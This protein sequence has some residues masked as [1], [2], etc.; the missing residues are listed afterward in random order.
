M[1]CLSMVSLCALSGQRTLSGKITNAAGEPLIGAN[2]L[3]KGTQAGTIANADGE[4]QL[5]VPSDA[6]ALLISY[7]GYESQEVPIGLTNEINVTL[8]EGV[9]MEEVVVS[10]LGIDRNSRSVPYSNQTVK[11]DEL[12]SSPNKNALAALQG[13]VAGVRISEGSGSPGA[14]TRIIL[15][16]EG[17]LTGNNNALI[18]ID[19]IP[20]D[21]SATR[22]GDPNDR[23]NNIA[24]FGFADYGN[25]FN[26]LNPADIEAVTVLKGPSATSLYGS[27]GASGVVLITT[28]KGSSAQDKF[29][30]GINSSYSTERAYVLMQRQ[31]QYG[32]GYGIPF[33]DEYGHD[34]GENFSWGAPFDGVERPWT[35][36]VDT[37]GD[38]DLEWLSRPYSAVPDQLQT[39][40]DPG[41]TLTNNVNFSGSRKDFSYYVSY[42]NTSQ[43]GTLQNS[44]YNRNSFKVGS[45]A[46]L[47]E[48]LSS[49]FSVNYSL[50]NEN[51]T[52]EGSYAFTA[53]NP[54][55]NAL[56]TAINIPFEDLKDYTNPYHSFTGYYGSYT[57]NPYFLLNESINN[58]KIGNLLGSAQL[59][60][61]ITDAWK[62]NLKFGLNAIQSKFRQATP[63]YQY[64]DHYIWGD[65][66]DP[67]LRG[68][69]AGSTGFYGESALNNTNIDLTA[70]TTYGVKFNDHLSADFSAGYNFFQRNTNRL[71]GQS[72]GGIVIPGFYSLS[73][74]AQAPIANNT[75]SKYRLLGLFGNVSVGI[76]NRFFVEYSARNDW[77][78]TLPDGNNA[79][80]YQAVGASAI[81]SDL[82]GMEGD[83]ISF[84]KLRA[85]YGTT[86]KDA[87]QYLLNSVYVANPTIQQLANNHDLFFPING[88]AGY[89]LGNT[90][91]NPDLKPELT[92]TLEFG[93]D[94]AF[95]KDHIGLAY[96]YYR[97]KHSNQIVN[98]TL[99]NST[100]FTNT[101]KNLGEMENNGHELALTLRPFV[102]QQRGGFQWEVT[103]LYAKNEN[104]V[105]KVNPENDQD[106][107]TI[108]DFG[109][110]V[111]VAKVGLPFG[112]F[113]GQVYKTNDQGQVVVDASGIPLLSDDLEY[114]GSFQPDWTGSLS[115][116]I[117]WKGFTLNALLDIKKGGEYLSYS[118]Y[119]VD[120]NGTSVS[121]LIGNRD[122]FVVPNSVVEN[123][124]GTYSENT[125]AVAPFDYLNLQPFSTSLIDASY[126]KL[127]EVSLK[128]D[129]PN[130]LT[131]SLPIDRGSI[132]VFARNLKFWLPDENQYADPEVNGPGQTGNATGIET[133]QT[134][135]S[136]SYG[137]TL[138]LI[139]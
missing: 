95:L 60:Y 137:V 128:Y 123:P 55:A 129:F 114:L 29:E 72:V 19:G 134:P 37:D 74:S 42:G 76:D 103:V 99:P 89:T 96:T 41:N 52:Q 122:Y 98:V 51:T 38:G 15:R 67:V 85:G 25:R 68:D 10:A 81:L 66:P 131:S 83:G 124:D 86:G 111:Q 4:Y 135:P 121:S 133:T 93:V 92:T 64:N 127:R 90:I 136:K 65:D 88:Q 110:I 71:D 113:K 3:A 6:T 57:T 139:F 8:R 132:G 23:L 63:Q 91:G 59:N 53:S 106:E 116:N 34:S 14:S 70:L 16:A 130:S 100:G 31:D 36:P 43:Q 11:A 7:T 21:N 35:S 138:S 102:S 32:Q 125:T 87:P 80:F 44:D 119:Y 104:E 1:L 120:F 54:Y 22:S 107:L 84:L 20:V 33:Q 30:V 40:F 26:D 101:I 112:T 18:V 47:T 69:R 49:D 2:V 115:T 126:I 27:R 117:G 50:V 78:S 75:E 108:D 77:S 73:N 118:K 28:K 12:L 9:F 105:T 13:K 82:L 17:S 62:L 79:F 97:S 46:K 48:K 58:G 56:Q 45:S 61:A 109:G 94:A 39:F 24:S 5:T